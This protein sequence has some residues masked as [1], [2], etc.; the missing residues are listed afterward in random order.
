M[1]HLIL[2]DKI[3][4]KLKIEKIMLKMEKYNDKC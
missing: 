1:P 3:K 2:V 4:T